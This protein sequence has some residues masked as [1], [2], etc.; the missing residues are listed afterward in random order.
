MALAIRI[1]IYCDESDRAGHVPLTTAIVQLLWRE[2]ATGVTVITGVEGFGGSRTIHSARGVELA[3]SRPCLVEWLDSPEKFESIWPRLQPLV[4]RVV[5]TRESV[6]LLVLPHHG[7]RKLSKDAVV[8]DVM[9]PAPVTVPPTATLEQVISTVI[10][11]GLRFVPVTDEGRL[12]GVI[13]NGDLVERAGLDARLELLAALGRDAAPPVNGRHA[14]DIMSREVVTIR[15]TARLREA[16][17]LMV[18]RGLKRLPVVDDRQHLVGIV[19]RADLL[20][21]IADIYPDDDGESTPAA[22][23]TAGDLATRHVPKVAPDT[24]IA[25]LVDR[26][27]S[28]RLNR[29]VVV[30]SEGRPIGVVSDTELLKRVQRADRGLLDRLMRRGRGGDELATTGQT[31]ADVMNPAPLLVRDSTPVLEAVR[32][33]MEGHRKLMVVVDADGRLVGTVD[34]AA[35]LRAAFG[36]N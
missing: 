11:H 17:A 20:R 3:A 30:D 34:R 2:H 19:S 26:V 10:E 14:E 24:P 8:A 36:L 9:E 12:V 32:Q 5:V 25:E 28:T 16:A 13:T 1:R 23:A 29:A 6:E 35:A 4:Q 7:L 21:S 15:P 33:M 18:E 31:A 27:A 22:G